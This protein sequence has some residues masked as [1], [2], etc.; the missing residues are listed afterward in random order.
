M[1]EI[2]SKYVVNAKT[3]TMFMIENKNLR[4]KFLIKILYNMHY[5]GTII[6][7]S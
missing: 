2:L 7:N 1:I 3:L 6:S 4:I 5:Q